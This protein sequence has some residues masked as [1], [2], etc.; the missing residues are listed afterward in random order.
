MERIEK[1][2]KLVGMIT[3][4]MINAEYHDPKDIAKD[5]NRIIKRFGTNLSDMDERHLDM[6]LDVIISFKT[7]IDNEES[8]ALNSHDDKMVTET[9]CYR[10]DSEHPIGVPFEGDDGHEYMAKAYRSEEKCKG[11]IFYD[12]FAEDCKADRA[13]SDACHHEDRLDDTEVIFE[14]ID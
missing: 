6:A 13:T 2:M 7:R 1:L 14:L 11:C 9:R 12:H 8:D 3:S 4:T 5:I 10:S